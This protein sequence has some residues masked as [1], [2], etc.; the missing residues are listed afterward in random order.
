M[1]LDERFDWMLAQPEG[2]YLERKQSIADSLG[3]TICGMANSTGGS[4]IIGVR[5]DGTLIGVSDPSDTAAKA[6]NIARTCQPP[7]EVVIEHFERRGKRLLL[8]EVRE[9]HDK[10]H[11]FGSVFYLRVGP[12]TQSMTREELAAM[13]QTTGQLRFEQ[14]PCRELKYPKDLD[15]GTFNTFIQRAALS[16]PRS[17]TDLLLNLGLAKTEGRRLVFN[18]AGALLFARKP[19]RFIP[20][21]PLDCVMYSG[22]DKV[23]ILDR[24]H[25]EGNLIKNVDEGMAF[26]RKNLRVRYEI[27]E[28]KRREILEIPEEALREALLNATVHR[29]Y[30]FE[31]AYATI[32]IFRD[33]VEISNPGGLPPGLRPEDFGRKAVRRNE[34]IAE[35]FH[36]M[37]EIERVGSGV[38]RILSST[39]SAGLRRPRFEFTTFFTL[40]FY[41]PGTRARVRKSKEKKARVEAQDRAH[42][43]AQV[44][45]QVL[46]SR[47]GVMIIEICRTPSS[48]S[49]IVRALGHSKRSGALTRMLNLLLANGLIR[50][51]IP[52]KP[53]SRNQRYVITELGGKLL[54]ERHR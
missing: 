29:D 15:I 23:D 35:I 18:D 40:T 44:R 12:M 36:R 7:A 24:K 2:Q 6:R 14:R 41:R 30:S 26:L 28:L 4:I 48:S 39:R 51:T 25:L 8:V 54:M 43:E 11:S 3:K 19:S 46:S 22:R 42:V 21:S 37:G 9:S 31:G 47:I 1:N 45:A 33:R 13:L 27:K 34:L 50:Y 52:G 5:P 16:R 32:E 53:H 20:H 49:E 38:G 17:R 10:P